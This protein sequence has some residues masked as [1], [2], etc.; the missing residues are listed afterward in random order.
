MWYEHG[1][2]PHCGIWFS[3]LNPVKLNLFGKAANSAQETNIS[4]DAAAGKWTLYLTGKLRVQ[5]R[6]YYKED[7]NE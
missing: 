5:V 2:T 7:L 4:T 1:R 6:Q 3:K